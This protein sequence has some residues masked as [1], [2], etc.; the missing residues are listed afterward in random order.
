MKRIAVLTS[1]GDAQGMNAAIRAIVRTALERGVEIYAISEGYQG[2]VEGGERIR[3]MNWNSVSGIL[4]LGGTVIGTAR[5]KEFITREGRL[6]AACNLIEYGIEGIIVIGGNGSLTGANIFR[7]QWSSL[8]TESVQNAR[9]SADAAQQHATLS[10]VGLVGSID[11]DFHGTDM[12]IGADTALNSIVNVVD[13]IKMSA[14]ATRSCLVVEVMGHR[15]ATWRQ[16][17]VWQLALNAFIYLKIAYPSK[18]YS[19]VWTC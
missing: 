18:I 16:W 8:L 1:G 12:T 7:E 4:Q 17:E 5:S 9:I 13:K 10:I 14:G 11:N 2:M 19:G 6:Q 3:K 15:C